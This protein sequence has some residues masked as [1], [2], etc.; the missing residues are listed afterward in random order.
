[1]KSDL[2]SG[3]NGFLMTG[4]KEEVG[5]GPKCRVSIK[6]RLS[7]GPDFQRTQRALLSLPLNEVHSTLPEVVRRHNTKE[8]PVIPVSILWM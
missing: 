8:C 3:L 4:N 7:T 2:I 5:R 6:R 1:M